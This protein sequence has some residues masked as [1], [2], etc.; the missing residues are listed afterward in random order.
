MQVSAGKCKFLAAGLPQVG[1]TVGASPHSARPL[2]SV[3]Q[4][5]GLL[6]L[7]AATVYKLCSDGDLPHARIL[8]TIRIVLADLAVFVEVR[9]HTSRSFQEGGGAFHTPSGPRRPAR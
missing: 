3:R 5:A 4:A 6:G 8:N 1:S 9:M 7:S 2:L